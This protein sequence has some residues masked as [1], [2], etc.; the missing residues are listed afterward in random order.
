MDFKLFPKDKEGYN[1]V[2]V[3]IDRLG[4]RIYLILYYKIT[5]VKE[6][7]QLFISNIYRTHSLLDTI[8]FDRGPQFISEF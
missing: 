8:I 4:K 7:A 2:Y 1:M 6:M 5:T 3:V